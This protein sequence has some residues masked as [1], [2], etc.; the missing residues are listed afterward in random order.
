MPDL[1]LMSDPFTTI[2]NLIAL[3]FVF[4]KMSH[5]I[6]QYF[7]G[8]VVNGYEPIKSMYRANMA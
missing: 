4:Y 7:E 3:G 2:L 6:I 1:S 5:G 8:C